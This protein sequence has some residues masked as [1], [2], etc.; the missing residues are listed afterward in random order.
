MNLMGIRLRKTL[1]FVDNMELLN[2]RQSLNAAEPHSTSLFPLHS[3][4][5]MAA[6][7]QRWETTRIKEFCHDIA[8]E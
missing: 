7:T 5:K 3:I 4:S 8:S 6:L 2:F 1:G